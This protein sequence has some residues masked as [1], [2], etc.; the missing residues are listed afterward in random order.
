MKQLCPPLFSL[1]LLAVLLQT[2]AIAN[3]S[4]PMRS[5]NIEYEA[6]SRTLGT[7]RKCILTP[8][9]LV[10]KFQNKS[11][12]E[13]PQKTDRQKLIRLAEKAISKPLVEAQSAAPRTSERLAVRFYPS[14]P[15]DQKIVVYSS[16]SKKTE[17]RDANS[18]TQLLSLMRTLCSP[19]NK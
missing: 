6:G 1:S 9:A 5:V 14:F 18:T 7:H 10:V 8:F 11:E 15:V 12:Q 13:F 4:S 17:I 3:A 19:Q 2:T 16:S